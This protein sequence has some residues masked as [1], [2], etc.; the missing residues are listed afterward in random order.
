MGKSPKKLRGTKPA[1]RGGRRTPRATNLGVRGSHV[2][3]GPP[4]HAN[5]PGHANFDPKRGEISL[6]RVGRSPEHLAPSAGRGGLGAGGVHVNSGPPGHANEPGHANFDPKRGRISSRPAERPDLA[7]RGVHV[8]S[9]PP[10]HANEP[11]HANFDPKVHP[12]AGEELL[13][14]T[15]PDGSRLTLPPG[16]IDITVRGYRIRR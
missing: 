4:G 13:H 2:N 12:A 1:G 15:L 11:G 14:V 3:S 7:T 5:E 8:N 9:G 6:G 16:P 10:G